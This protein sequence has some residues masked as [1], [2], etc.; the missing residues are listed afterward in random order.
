MDC[1][2]QRN[3]LSKTE[4]PENNGERS[5]LQSIIWKLA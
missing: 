5:L 1:I 3:A 2:R 4:M